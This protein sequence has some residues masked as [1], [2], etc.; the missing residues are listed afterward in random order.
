[1][2]Q[3]YFS[4][5]PQKNFPVHPRDDVVL[6]FGEP[7][8]PVKFHRLYHLVPVADVR[9]VYISWC[10]PA[11]L[12]K[13][14]PSKPLR[15]IRFMLNSEAEGG[16]YQYLRD[17][18]W[19]VHF[20]SNCSTD[21]AIYRNNFCSLYR[22]YF[23]L[24][25]EGFR[26]R[27][28]VIAALK[29]YINLLKREGPKEYLFEELRRSEANNFH[30]HNWESP[31]DDTTTISVALQTIP[32]EHVL[33]VKTLI[34][35]FDQKQIKDALCMM[36][37]SR[38]NIIIMSR[39]FEKEECQTVTKNRRFVYTSQPI[40]PELYENIGIDKYFS[41]PKGSNF[42]PKTIG[43]PNPQE[44]LGMEDTKKTHRIVHDC[45]MLKMILFSNNPHQD[46]CHTDRLPS[47]EYDILIHSPEFSPVNLPVISVKIQN[48]E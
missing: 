41:Y 17:R 7:F 40:P 24:T 31:M 23:I 5:I 43:C 25:E 39:D 12:W 44:Y 16:L 38:A 27:N 29:S 6:K 18:H 19:V 10:L 1:M 9:W 2:A 15:Y 8:D 33:T 13:D 34:T 36:D 45:P 20:S 21:D 35:R 22:I 48:N 37:I 26:N 14:Y 30:Y 28:K 11:W 42:F 47:A 46:K 4:D 3:R 32:P